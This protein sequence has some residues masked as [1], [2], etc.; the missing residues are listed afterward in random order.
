MIAV[1]QRVARCA[2]RIDDREHSSIGRGLLVL[3]GVGPADGEADAGALA[4]K[5]VNLRI[6]ED[7]EGKMNASLLDIGGQLMAVSQFT[8]CA[9]CRR[10]RRPSFTNAAPPEL[11]ERL[12]DRFVG[13]VRDKGVAV[14]TGKFGAKMLVEI[15]NDGPVTITLD[16]AFSHK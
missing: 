3:L 8:L 9:D 11:G 4:D 13:A 5:I 16:T 15:A 12:Y 1:I 14:A 10:G 6:F 7:A 2:V